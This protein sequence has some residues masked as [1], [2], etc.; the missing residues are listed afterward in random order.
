MARR[1]S[2]IP[3][4]VLIA[5]AAAMWG[6]DALFRK[7]LAEST[8]AGTIVFGE[9]VILV[10]LTLP[11]IVPAMRALFAAGTR[12]VLAGIAIGAGASAV[13]TIL[14]T[15][16][17][18]RG[19]PIT[20]VVLQKVQ[21]LI[22]IAAAR[23]ILGEQPRRGFVWFV[24]P[25]LLGVW[26]IAFPHPFDVHASGLEP[27]A[28]ALGAAVLWGLGTVFGRYLSRRLPFE[29]V[30]TVRFSFG[31]VASAIMLP[32]LGA[33]AFASA[34]DTL[35]IA[36][37]ALVTGAAALSLYYIGLQRTPAMVA[38]IAELAYPVTAVIVGYVAFDATLRW[39]QWLGVIVTVGVVSLLPAPRRKPLVKVPAGEPQ[40]APASA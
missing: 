9:H 10:L 36:Y 29:H 31:L 7:P 13:A 23:V 40:L 39:T 22:V 8:S 1:L 27:I 26:L 4:V 37:L 34:H 11:L 2:A 28:L 14:F 16:A 5:A 30:V 35:W 25:A 20:P 15:Q 18:V 19:D 24:I 6:T 3:G 33:P 38:S 12:Y 32:I 17:F 21:P